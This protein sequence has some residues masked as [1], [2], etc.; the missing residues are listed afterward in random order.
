MKHIPD[1][2]PLK[3]ILINFLNHVSSL[4]NQRSPDNTYESEF[5]VLSMLYLRC[6]LI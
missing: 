2:I 6:I 5:Q 3:T 1:K 4:E